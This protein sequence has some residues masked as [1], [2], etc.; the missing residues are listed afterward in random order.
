MS[1]E[2]P[3]FSRR[4][5]LQ[6][7]A[8]SALLAVTRTRGAAGPVMIAVRI[9]P[10]SAYTR[11]TLESSGP[12]R[13]R[14]FRLNDPERLVVDIEDVQLNQ[15]VKQAAGSVSSTDPYLREVRAGQFTAT[16]LRIVLVL[17]QQV[18]PKIFALTP[19]ADFKH[20]LVVDLYSGLNTDGD[21]L[22]AFLARY[23]AGEAVTPP[24]PGKAGRDRPLIVMI[25]PGHGGEDPG[26]RGKA[27]TRE[28]DIVLSISRRLKKLIDK[29]PLMTAFM[30]RS[31]DVFIP[32]Q[33]RVAKAQRLKADMF[34]SIHADSFTRPA[35]NG[36]SV[37]ALSTRGAT[38]AAARFLADS[39]NA[40]DSIGGVNLSGDLYLDR[41]LFDMLQRRTISDSL[42]LG[43]HMLRH[44]GKI[45]RLHKQQVDQAGFAVLKAPDIPSVLVETAFISHPQE[46]KKLRTAGY[47]QQVA[48]AIV[49]GIK[50][51]LAEWRDA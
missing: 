18:T 13:Y 22:T 42:K 6:A 10:S 36:A 11:V 28:K 48:E 21:P 9:W 43:Q 29:Q 49:G 30:T 39:Q 14:Q 31:D 8:V 34:I 3:F 4:R 26:A 35:A 24:A 50:D 7:T 46:E 45:T 37:F 27:G 1:A 44:M 32:L 38:S 5:L 33:V 2:Y 20:R 17:K 41:T 15:V 40:S 51:Y 23:S 25:D 19:V 12:L 16:T 47:Q